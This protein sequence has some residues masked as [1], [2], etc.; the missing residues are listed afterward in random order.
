MSSSP[1]VKKG[2]SI[3][4]HSETICKVIQE[5]AA[6]LTQGPCPLGGNIY[7]AKL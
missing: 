3:S 7:V 1:P 4:L 2:L 5:L 6:F